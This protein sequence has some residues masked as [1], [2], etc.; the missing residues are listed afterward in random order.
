[1]LNVSYPNEWKEMHTRTLLNE[2]WVSINLS[3]TDTEATE[4]AT[5]SD[6]GHASISDVST[7]TDEGASTETP[8]YGTLEQNLWVL[9]GNYR[10]ITYS[11]SV[12][13]GYVSD[14]LSDDTG[15]F[16]T[17]NPKITIDF[18]KV[19]MTRLP[20]ITIK[21]SPTYREYADTFTVSV[22]KGDAR[23][24]FKRIT[25]NR[26]TESVIF[27]DIIGYNRIEIVIEKWCL[28]SR[29]ARVEAIFLGISKEFG[30]NELI[31]Y[32]HRMSVDPLSL[33]LPKNEIQFSVDN[34]NREYD[35][36]NLLGIS[37]YLAQRQPITITYRCKR[38]NGTTQG[39]QAGRFFLS[40][41]E[42]KR[43]GITAEFKARDAFAFMSNTYRDTATS[44]QRR[45]LYQLLTAVCESIEL[46][47]TTNS[48]GWVTN[49]PLT[50]NK[51]STT[52]VLPEETVANCIQLIAN[53]AECVFKVESTGTINI[54]SLQ[55]SSTDT[56]YDADYTIDSFNSYTK[57][58]L[59]LSKPLKK[60]IVKVYTYTQGS[61][62][63]ESSVTDE[64]VISVGEEGETV[65]IDNP[66]IT[67]IEW[68]TSVGNWVAS[69]LSKRA[70]IET[71]WRPDVRL[72]PLDIIQE[73]DDYN[74]HRVRMTEIEYKYNGAFRGTGKGKVM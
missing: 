51:I 34:S 26:S 40:E 50:L 48:Q 41:W 49:A 11:G 5:V 6:N 20:G 3:L 62:G 36:A 43:N 39:V 21:W 56:S 18:S 61:N 69:E 14:V 73:T 16:S 59:T 23:I 32:S 54:E 44:V 64:A 38:D 47:Y 66:L 60:V 12:T 2:Q 74:T 30:K 4:D 72:Q 33:S 22:Y 53:A 10:A 24:N 27:A 57:P 52:A 45:T 42:A 13:N 7:V 9:D 71:S 70:S 58:E 67:D 29:R 46:P 15:V 35:F 19:F 55:G 63:I 31:S 25:G 8:M 1:M 68:A 37:Q 65:T 17:K 28:P